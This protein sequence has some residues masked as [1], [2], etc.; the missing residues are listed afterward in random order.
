MSCGTSHRLKQPPQQT[1]QQIWGE[2]TQLR[3]LQVFLTGLTQ[4]KEVIYVHVWN[5]YE[6]KMTI[7]N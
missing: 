7:N 4:E 2:N 3:P 6:F 1:G 5:V